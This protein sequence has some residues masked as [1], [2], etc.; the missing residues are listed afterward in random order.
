LARQPETPNPNGATDDAEVDAI[1]A[2]SGRLAQLYLAPLANLFA[3]SLRLDELVGARWTHNAIGRQREV[4][5][6]VQTLSDESLRL[7][8][9]EPATRMALRCRGG[10]RRIII[11]AAAELDAKAAEA[12]DHHAGVKAQIRKLLMVMGQRM[13][14]YG[15]EF[16][17]VGLSDE[18]KRI[19][20]SYFGDGIKPRSHRR[21]AGGDSQAVDISIGPIQGLARA[22]ARTD[23]IEIAREL[24]RVSDHV[25]KRLER[26]LAEL[27]AIICGGPP[28]DAAQRRELL[29]RYFDLKFEEK[30][31][32]LM[33]SAIAGILRCFGGQQR[34]AM[35][36][37]FRES[38][39]SAAPTD[40]R[41]DAILERLSNDVMKRGE[42]KRAG[43]Q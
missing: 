20:K 33:D 5:S 2:A 43:D 37:A 11:D 23:V 22:L 28:V 25:I 42:A 9:V 13:A 1:P 27:D 15:I 26:R 41:V 14:T 38:E 24:G 39:Q 17:E 36:M 34:L 19:F 8:A 21:A 16:P 10:Y 29:R 6:V 7:R 4:A 3:L 31:L 40:A 30:R 18:E 32:P 12:Y 35:E